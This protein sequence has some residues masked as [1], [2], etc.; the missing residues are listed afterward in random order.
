[1][2]FE[3]I[4][5]VLLP[6]CIFMTISFK[7]PKVSKSSYPENYRIQTE[8]NIFYVNKKE[9]LREAY[10]KGLKSKTISDLIRKLFIGKVRI[11]KPNYNNIV[12]IIN[13]TQE[14]LRGMVDSEKITQ[15]EANHYLNGM[16]EGYEKRSELNLGF[17]KR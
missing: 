7:N 11:I 3:T 1:M 12:E 10:D 8:T 17:L 16:I 15:Q 4:L 9:A 5:Q 13:L 14:G 6:A 2:K